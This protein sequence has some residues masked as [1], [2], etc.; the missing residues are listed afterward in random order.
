MSVL[1]VNSELAFLSHLFGGGRLRGNV[2]DSSL[3]RWKADSRLSIARWKACGR[4]RI[5]IIEHLSL[6]VTVEML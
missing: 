2:C 5:R 6:A 3:A 1:L 4:L